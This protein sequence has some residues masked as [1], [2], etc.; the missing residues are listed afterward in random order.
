MGNICKRTESDPDTAWKEQNKAQERNPIFKLV[1]LSKGG[2][3]IEAYKTGGSAA[4]EKIAK[5]ELAQFL[6]NDGNG[7]NVTVADYVRW[8]RQ[9]SSG[10]SIY[11]YTQGP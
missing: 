4:V 7:H 8:Q 1:N 11:I 6:Y 2:K 3:L 10:V 5:T 9:S